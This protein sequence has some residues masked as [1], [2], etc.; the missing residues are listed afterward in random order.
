MGYEALDAATFAKWGCDYLKAD[1]C[2]N[3]A[4]YPQGY[5][6]LGSALQATGKDV[7]Y[8]CSWPA[9]L[10]DDE[11]KKPFAAFIAAGCNRK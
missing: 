4:N 2:G 3:P 9:Y 5:P 11:T 7:V 8:S 10:G 6:A 1:G